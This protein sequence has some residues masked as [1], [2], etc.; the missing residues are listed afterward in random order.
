MKQMKTG[1]LTQTGLAL[2]L[3]CGLALVR[4]SASIS[5][6]LAAAAA[7]VALLAAGVLLW[8]GKKAG[9]WTAQPDRLCF[10][11]LALSGFLFLIAA[12]CFAVDENAFVLHGVASSLRRWVVLLFALFCGVCTL[13][14]LAGR[15][16]GRKSAACSLVPVFCMACCLL[17]FYRSNGDNPYLADFGVDIVVLALTL[18]G[19]YLAASTRF[20]E[21]R[22]WVAEGG[23]LLSLT[24]IVQELLFALLYWDRLREIPGLSIGLLMLM[25]ACGV[26]VLCGLFC[27]P[28][29]LPPLPA[30]D[31]EDGDGEETPSEEASDN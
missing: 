16:Q 28:E 19:V 27:T 5:V 14:R 13:L 4:A 6:L 3:G 8:P 21:Q 22:R 29:K 31:E 17:I 12:G 18:L 10:A 11:L 25:A 24:G 23:L 9:A 2:L 1:R 30:E 7:A 26:L 20:E 15:D